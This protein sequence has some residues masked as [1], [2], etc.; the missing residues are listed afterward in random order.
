MTKTEMWSPCIG[1]AM[2]NPQM[3][4]NFTPVRACVCI[5]VRE[6]K[7]RERERDV[8]TKRN[9]GNLLWSARFY[10]F[11]LFIFLSIAISLRKLWTNYYINWSKSTRFPS[12]NAIPFKWKLI[13][14]IRTETYLVSIAS[15]HFF[16]LLLHKWFLFN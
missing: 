9:E 11:Y 5:C 1:I 13:F 2:I 4:Y 16:F 6:E 3:S 10:P 12:K 14:E 8:G 7:V 15:I